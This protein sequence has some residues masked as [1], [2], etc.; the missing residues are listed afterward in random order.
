MK[1]VYV[2]INPKCDL[3]VVVFEKMGFLESVRLFVEAD[4]LASF[5]VY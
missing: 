5:G 1:L 3:S 2:D 4:L